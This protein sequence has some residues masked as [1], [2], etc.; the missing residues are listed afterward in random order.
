MEKLKIRLIP[1]DHYFIPR[2]YYP[3]PGMGIWFTQTHLGPAICFRSTRNN[4]WRLR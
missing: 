1:W 2:L 4:Y 3:N